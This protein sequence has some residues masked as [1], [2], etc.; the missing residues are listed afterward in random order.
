MSGFD[1]SFSS[2][3]SSS[4][5]GISAA[6]FLFASLPF[7]PFFLPSLGALVIGALLLLY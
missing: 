3:S 1:G 4:I 5:V 2:C 6:G 7:S